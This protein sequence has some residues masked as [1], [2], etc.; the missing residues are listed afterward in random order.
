MQGRIQDLCLGGA[1]AGDLGMEVWG[2]GGVAPP[3]DGVTPSPTTD[4]WGCHPKDIFEKLYANLCI[5]AS[6]H[7]TLESSLSNHVF[8]N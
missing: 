3:L 7:L 2:V 4:V 5:L 8:Q 1:L 6:K